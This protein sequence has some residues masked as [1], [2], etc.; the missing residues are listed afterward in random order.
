MPGPLL[1]DLDGTIADT[2]PVIAE[3]LHVV[4]SAF[5][6]EM[7]DDFQFA[8][9]PPLHWVLEQLGFDEAN[10]A[11]AIATFET[12][13]TERITLIAPMP[14]ADVVIRELASSGVKIGIATIKP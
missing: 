5:D 8:F 11:D 14:G 10:M 3:C 4:C 7:P 6:V 1:S 9:G 13:H 2:A 12:A